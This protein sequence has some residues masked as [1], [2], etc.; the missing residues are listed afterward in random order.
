MRDDIDKIMAG[1]DYEITP[2]LPLPPKLREKVGRLDAGNDPKDSE[3]DQKNLTWW[4]KNPSPVEAWKVPEGRKISEYF[5]RDTEVGKSNRALLPKH[6]HHNPKIQGER[7][8]CMTYQNGSCSA[9]CGL[10]HAPPDR[11]EP[12]IKDQMDKAVRKIYK[13][14]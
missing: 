13:S 9:N 14:S 11:M 1:L 7:G 8:V 4:T 5:G 12:S 6:K 2:V 10:A 3:R